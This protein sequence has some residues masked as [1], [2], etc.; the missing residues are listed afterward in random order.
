MAPRSDP[1]QAGPRL[2]EHVARKEYLCGDPDNRGCARRIL[3]G[4]TY[5]Q[6][7]YAPHTKPFN[8]ATWVIIRACSACH[9]PTRASLAACPIGATGQ[10][11][12][13]TAGHD[14]GP[15][16]TPH[17]YNEGLF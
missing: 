3:K 11:C 14:Q 8:A 5:V 16:P 7:S 15:N 13:R 12:L 10:T 1:A 9:P 6:L 2:A 17:E 4:D